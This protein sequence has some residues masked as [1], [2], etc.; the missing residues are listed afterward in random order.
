VSGGLAQ[1]YEHGSRER[2]QWWAPSGGPASQPR[3][4][5][6]CFLF[7]VDYNSCQ[8]S[9]FNR[10]CSCVG[11]ST[12]FPNGCYFNWIQPIQMANSIY[13]IYFCPTPLVFFSTWHWDGAF[14]ARGAVLAFLLRR[15]SSSITTSF[16]LVALPAR[17]RQ[18]QPCKRA[19]TGHYVWPGIQ[20]RWVAGRA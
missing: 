3:R 12:V 6:G 13:L 15:W 16:S 10:K 8:S 18:Q 1:K 4:A 17:A 9:L 14:V 19:G 20:E 2:A 7:Q 5:V 11:V